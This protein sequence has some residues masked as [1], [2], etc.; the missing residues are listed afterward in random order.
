MKLIEGPAT[1]F[2]KSNIPFH[3]TKRKKTFFSFAFI[4]FIDS[5]N[6]MEGIEK[7]L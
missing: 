5:M 7:I 1:P 2:I 4:S 3:Q 6:G